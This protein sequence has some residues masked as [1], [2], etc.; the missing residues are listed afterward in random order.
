VIGATLGHY[1]ILE[2]LGEGGMGVVYR[3]RDL[4]LERD[5]AIKMLSETRNDDEARRRLRHEARFL[6][7]VNHPNVETIYDLGSHD[8]VD[9][10]VTELV[11]GRSLA[12]RAREGVLPEREPVGYAI[13]LAH[14]LDSIHGHGI[15]H[16]DL[17][18]ANVM[19]TREGIVKVVDF[20]VARLLPGAVGS[21]D[22]TSTDAVTIAGTLP[23]MA[24]EVLRGLPPEP[25]SDLYSMGAILYELATGRPPYEAETAGALVF[26]ILGEPALPPRALNPALSPEFEAI[27]MRCL[28][29]EPADRQ[30]S[31]GEL[32]AELER[33]ARGESPGPAH[34]APGPAEPAARTRRPATPGRWRMVA[35]VLGLLAV[36]AIASALAAALPDIERLLFSRRR[37]V[38]GRVVVAAFTNGTGEPAL[39]AIGRMASDW[40]S[41]GLLGTGLVEV[42]QPGTMLEV[43]G[44]MARAGEMERAD[45]RIGEETQAATV[46]TGAY[47]RQGDS[48][49]FQARILET[50]TGR[51]LEALGPE[52]TAAS[53]PLV[54]IEALRRRVTAGL[55]AQLHPA[56]SRWVG[57]ASK[58]PSYEAY[59]EYVDGLDDYVRGDWPQALEHYVRSAAL[60]TTYFDARLSAGLASLNLDRHAQ[61]DSIA[62]SLRAVRGRLSVPERH[63][64]D[65]MEAWCSGDAEAA[66]HASR[67]V[68][69]VAPASLWSYEY[70]LSALLTN[71]PQEAVAALEKIDPGHGLYRDWAPYWE[72]LTAAE[73]VLGDYR[74]ELRDARRARRQHPQLSTILCTEIRAEAALGRSDAVDRLAELS[75][76]LPEQP[77][78][79][80]GAVMRF[81]A[82]ELRAH[83][84]RVEARRMAGLAVA[85]HEAELAR[86][87]AWRPDRSGLAVA[88]YQAERWP[89]AADAFERLA[90]ERP[91]DVHLRGYRG[92]IAARMGRRDSALAHLAALERAD[93]TGLRGAHT[94]WCADIAALLGERERAFA[95]LL[96]AR[97]QGHPLAFPMH[98]DPDLEPLR[99]D[100]RFA[101]LVE[102]IR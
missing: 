97:E 96:R 5:V 1:R 67:E 43:S 102:P 12:A 28:A 80:P 41:Q 16:R 94:Y 73:H 10:L 27:A 34:D 62:R 38:P 72:T 47:Y 8:G 90:R 66:L 82:R 26:R 13:A 48:L 78:W 23:Y 55:A 31:A 77:G 100:P 39:D 29:R 75:R 54:A 89:E 37:L 11:E 50:A 18:P 22:S 84:R 42:V 86:S 44:R 87:A 81:A 63:V 101:A 69:A 7:R 92:V 19:L 24:P 52:G 14:A 98:A 71:R 88:L 15:V 4:S 9:F 49:L 83:G 6:S 74:R 99:D 21:I 36:V 3:A 53:T 2:K 40:I 45:V 60:D 35:R 68:A 20:G 64:L 56:L 76:T 58:P 95:L 93:G 30:R 57:A 17:K 61:V 59:R 70:A 51:V 25:A 32:A 46:V 91:L 65:W 79:S 33:L 85:W